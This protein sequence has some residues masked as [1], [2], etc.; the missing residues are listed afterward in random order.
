MSEGARRTRTGEETAVKSKRMNRS[1][2]LN[3]LDLGS[4]CGTSREK[5]QAYSRM[6]GSGIQE[7][8]LEIQ[9][10]EI[11]STSNN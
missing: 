3:L 10:S 9:I 1:L 4:T 7:Y 5:Y 11:T 8:R 6:H 2:V